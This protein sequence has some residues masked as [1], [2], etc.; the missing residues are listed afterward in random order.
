M[1]LLSGLLQAD[2]LEFRGTDYNRVVSLE[3]MKQKLQIHRIALYDPYYKKQK[4][5]KAFRLDEALALGYPFPLN[6]DTLTFYAQDGYNPTL[7]SGLN[8]KGGWLAIEDLS[9]EGGWEPRGGAKTMGPFYLVWAGDHERAE[10]GY[11]WPARLVAIELG[12]YQ[13]KYAH[14][15]P[16]QAPRDSSVYKGY[17]LFRHRC[18]VCHGLNRH[19]G[20]K[21][22]DLLAPRAIVSYRSQEFLKEFIKQPSAFRYSKMP[23]NP[24]LSDGEIQALLDYLGY[25]AQ[26]SE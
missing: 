21:G 1:C 10:V 8:R 26:D 15:V 11:P 18:M 25:L 23:G 12:N 4:T 6:Q 14:A 16:K 7:S 5:Y 22:P 19:G 17:E 13:D 24:D 20:D 3:E 2:Q 9:W